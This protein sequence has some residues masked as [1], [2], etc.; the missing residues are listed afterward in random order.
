MSDHNARLHPIIIIAGTSVTIAAL[1]AIA[2]MLG[3]V[4]TPGSRTASHSETVSIET[5]QA[6]ARV[7]SPAPPAA[8]LT[9]PS[10]A[11]QKAAAAPPKKTAARDPAP[12]ARERPLGSTQTHTQSRT[13]TGSAPAPANAPVCTTCGTVTSIR[14]VQQQ[15]EAGMLGPIAG[16][17]VG[18]A[19]GSQIGGGSGRA[20]A[21]IAGA[22]GGAAV[23]TEIERRTKSTTTYVVNVRLDGGA[24]RSFNF[25]STPGYNTGDRVRIVDG[26]LVR[27][28]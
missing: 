10:R 17:V 22:A 23:G 13:V 25:A 14:T 3:L 4:P 15:G 9:A 1:L 2:M 27:G 8:N 12:L 28:G 18:G 21:T 7:T 5:P 26:R 11:E 6:P 19:A 20:L 24:T 16:G